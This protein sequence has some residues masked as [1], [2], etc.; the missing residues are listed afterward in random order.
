M[1]FCVIIFIDIYAGDRIINA[2]ILT[3]VAGDSVDGGIKR[4]KLSRV[5]GELIRFN[6]GDFYIDWNLK[7]GSGE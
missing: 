1:G 2:K 6:K 7:M 5:H 3:G 4:G